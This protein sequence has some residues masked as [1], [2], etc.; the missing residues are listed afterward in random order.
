VTDSPPAPLTCRACGRVPA[1]EFVI[2]RHVGLLI[3]QRFIKFRAAL[4][5]EHAEEITRHYL[6]LTLVQG[7][8][9]WISFFVNFFVI[10]TDVAALSKAKKMPPPVPA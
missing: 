4:C 5:R 9:G 1:Q 8:W 6:Q 10:A 3:L 7:W 2:R